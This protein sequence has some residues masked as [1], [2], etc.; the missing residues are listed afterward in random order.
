MS[1]TLTLDQ[2]SK[3]HLN[4]QFRLL[5]EAAPRSV[6]SAIMKVAY[7][8]AADASQRI[9]G[10]QH[11]V[12]GRLRS[13]IFV[14]TKTKASQAYSDDFNKSFVSELPSIAIGLDEV[15]IGTNV[16]YAQKIES[17]YPFL[18]W[19]VANFDIQKSIGDEAKTTLENV[20][21]YGKGLIPANR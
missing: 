20:M 8:I 6:Y 13:S 3:D 12:T 1:A 14:K 5:R 11:V 4:K 21:K 7:K 2:G 17:K 19:A 15:A 16:E 10:Q 18:S 9:K